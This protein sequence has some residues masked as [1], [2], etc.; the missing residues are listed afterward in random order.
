MMKGTQFNTG[1]LAILKGGGGA[2]R[3]PPF[4]REAQRVLPCLKKFSTHVF[5]IFVVPPPVINDGSLT[6]LIC[7]VVQFLS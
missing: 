3:C 1:V 5:P 7:M 6:S 4:K 2:K